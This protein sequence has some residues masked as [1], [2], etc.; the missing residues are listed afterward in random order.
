MHV[1]NLTGED[2]LLKNKK[3]ELFR[4][5]PSQSQNQNFE[6]EVKMRDWNEFYSNIVIED[7]G[8]EEPVS[9]KNIS[10][11]FKNLPPP[12]RNSIYIVD[13][14]SQFLIRNFTDRKDFFTTHDKHICCVKRES[15]KPSKSH[16]HE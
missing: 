9:I 4:I 13:F 11:D 15:K 16:E 1:I 14:C 3:N 5:F 6:I 7:G 2:I 8:F 10:F 12:L